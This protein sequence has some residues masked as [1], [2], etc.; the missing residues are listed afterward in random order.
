MHRT[1]PEHAGQPRHPRRA[2]R[3]GPRDFEWE[4]GP[5]RLGR[6]GPRGPRRGRK[7]GD[8]RAA[9]LLLLAEAPAHGY[10]L[11]QQIAARS[12]GAWSPSPGSIYP[13]LQQLE[14]EGLIEFERVEGRKTAT[15]T[16]TGTAYVEE[17]REALGEPW[18]PEQLGRGLVAE[19]AA[20]KTSIGSFMSAAKQVMM[21][22]TPAQQVQAAEIVTEA[23]RRLYGLLADDVD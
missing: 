17:N 7:G 5:G 11:I 22:G 20:L 14:D 21:V 13:V 23:R 2:R 4:V 19:A 6:P 1:H 16:D 8:V 12:E 18:N 10:H 15:L 3:G 9:A